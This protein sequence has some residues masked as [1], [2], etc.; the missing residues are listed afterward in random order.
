MLENQ[1]TYDLV[2]RYP[3]EYRASVEAI[4]NKKF[5]IG[6]VKTGHDRAYWQRI[7]QLGELAR[8]PFAII[9][10]K[11][12]DIRIELYVEDSPMTVDNFIQLS[13]SGFYNGLSFM[14][15]VPNFVIQTGDPRGDGRRRR[16]REPVRHPGTRDA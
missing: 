14:R 7:A 1:R 4:G 12:G 3:D 16:S 6:S 9:H 8:N 2:V 15:V 10:T 5:H 11:K 13:R